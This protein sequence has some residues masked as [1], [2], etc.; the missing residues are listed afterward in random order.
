MKIQLKSFTLVELLIV[1]AIISILAA[2]LLP[3][4]KKARESAM[5][6]TCKNHLKQNGLAFGSY[7]VDYDGNVLTYIENSSYPHWPRFLME[8]DYGGK[9][10]DIFVCPSNY[11]FKYN[12]D[13]ALAYGVK[14]SEWAKYN[15]QPDIDN[16]SAFIEETQP[17]GHV[18]KMVNVERYKQPTK[19]MLLTD[20]VFTSD[21]YSRKKGWQK[22]SLGNNFHIRHNHR[23]NF[24]WGDGHVSSHNTNDIASIFLNTVVAR[25]IYSRDMQKI[26][27]F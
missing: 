4:L 3:A 16:L 15:Y 17:N 23:A 14:L 22:Y 12:D 9:N 5:D 13:P 26:T 24:L 6:I 2:L 18:Y 21:S 7:S 11:P 1:I 25:Y 27:L 8:G 19:N 10:Y 20:S